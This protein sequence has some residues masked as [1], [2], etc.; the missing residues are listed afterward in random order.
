MMLNLCHYAPRRRPAGGPLEKAFVP[1]NRFVT[2]PP[3]RPQQ[4]IGHIPFQ[5]LSLAAG[6]A[7]TKEKDGVSRERARGELSRG[8]QRIWPAVLLASRSRKPA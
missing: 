5:V 3:H 6:R 7:G 8:T 4:Q 1:H 2:E